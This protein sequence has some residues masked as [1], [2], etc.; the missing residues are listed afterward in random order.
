MAMRGVSIG[1]APAAG[2]PAELA[3]GVLDLMATLRAGDGKT[4]HVQINTLA[5]PRGAFRAG[6]VMLAAAADRALL[7]SSDLDAIGRDFTD[8]LLDQ[9]GLTSRKGR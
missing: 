5:D 2:R 1:P 9:P 7:R 4:F 8:H 6:A 3:A